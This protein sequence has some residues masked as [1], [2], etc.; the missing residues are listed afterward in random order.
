LKEKRI[1]LK[2]LFISG[3]LKFNFI[4]CGFMDI[5][6]E[7]RKELRKNIDKKYKKTVQGFFKREIKLYGVRSIIV[8]KISKKYYKELMLKKYNKKE[9]FKLCE[10]L[11]KTNIM[12]EASIA[13]SWMYNLKEEYTKSDFKIFENIIKKYVNNWAK[14]DDFCCHTL[15]YFI[16]K[17]PKYIKNLKKWAKDKN[18][19]L[20]RASAVSLIYPVRKDKKFLKSIFE[21]SDILLQDKED[22]VQKGYGWALKV[23]A[24]TNQKQVFNYVMKNKHK[25]PRTALRYAIEKM[26]KQLK[27]KAMQ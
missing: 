6:I 2:F 22:L 1:L 27:G 11:L 19:W 4:Y 12:E 24:D 18:M 5:L 10:N 16:Y 15:G 13:F 25:M 8:K 9:I 23:G 14:C 3:T 17:N 21:I 26:P 7:I 20:R